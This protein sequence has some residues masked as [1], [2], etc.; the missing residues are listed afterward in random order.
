MSLAPR[1]WN[2]VVAGAWNV[3]ILTPKG[4]AKRLFR[5]GDEV[6]VEV[7]INLEGPPLVRVRYDGLIVEPSSQR[8]VVTPVE[9]TAA[10]LKKA[11]NVALAA[12]GGL[13]ETPFIAAGVNVRFVMAE[14]PDGLLDQTRSKLA[15]VL[16]ETY[17]IHARQIRHTLGWQA[18]SL[19]MEVAQENDTH[20]SL[21][22]NFHRQSSD[23]AELEEWLALTDDMVRSART[24]LTSAFGI[25]PQEFE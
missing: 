5:L 14:L 2:V 22:F 3:A 16:D 7:L 15:D 25:N 8:L 20:G 6:P 1:D 11:A 12:L 24:L 21:V 10:R 19:N 23:R 9:S 4:I 13:P 17:E 18:G